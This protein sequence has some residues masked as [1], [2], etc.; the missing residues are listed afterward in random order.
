MSPYKK[1]LIFNSVMF[2][3]FYGLYFYLFSIPTKY[4]ETLG[5][6]IGGFIIH[7]ICL[8]IYGI[9]SYNI[10]KSVI[11]PNLMLFAFL[12]VG[13]S[14]LIIGFTLIKG[15][16]L[17]VSGFFQIMYTAFIGILFSLIPSLIKK[18]ITVIKN[19]KAKSMSEE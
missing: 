18:S 14:C 4:W 13:H 11:Y 12:L 16:D 3:L 6:I 10:T 7:A 2:V 5:F 9:V 17:F 19:R 8:L 1:L 15:Q